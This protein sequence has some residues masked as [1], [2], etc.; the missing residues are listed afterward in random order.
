M[1][2]VALPSPPVASKESIPTVR[3]SK[4]DTNLSSHT[5]SNST[6]P[7]GTVASRI[8]AKAA[9]V[10]A[11][12]NNKPDQ[13]EQTQP[14]GH[15]QDGSRQPPG[16]GHLK[17]VPTFNG[18][19]IKPDTLP[20][21]LETMDDDSDAAEAIL[22]KV[23]TFP[24]TLQLTYLAEGAANIIYRISLGPNSPESDKEY[25]D[26]LLRLRKAL[27]SSS[28]NLPAYLSLLSRFHPLL[29][30]NSTVG[31]E[32]VKLPPGI[33]IRENEGIKELEATLARKESRRGLYLA[34]DEH[35][36]FLLEDMTPHPSSQKS[37][38]EVLVEFKPKWLLQSPSAPTNAKRCR[39]CALRL[40]KI[41]VTHAKNQRKPDNK[42]KP[43]PANILH[44]AYCPFDLISE[45]RQC[46]RA[47]VIKML[48]GKGAV[49]LP[50]GL[51]KLTEAQQETLIDRTTTVLMEGDLLKQLKKIQADLDR[52]GMVKTLAGYR[53]ESRLEEDLSGD[54]GRLAT[55]MT[56]RDLT[57]FLR[58][59][60]PPQSFPVQY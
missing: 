53:D 47:A 33:I 13:K 40:K 31:T 3:I 1:T 12:T 7:M 10:T 59:R 54:V 38:P 37:G 60:H 55:A 23:R 41:A 32:L 43:I 44:S 49:R 26:K 8:V 27:P 56:L 5:N 25:T 57:L 52:Q 30:T 17:A 51:D 14:G 15:S 36:A 39:T 16:P 9:K 48:A 24:A 46:V 28:P 21:R 19:I 4:K 22:D 34:E 2:V 58:V 45:D 11:S 42:K 50:K 6:A 18:S 20:T 35:Y 29:P